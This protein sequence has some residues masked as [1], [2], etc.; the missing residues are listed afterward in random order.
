MFTSVP[1]RAM[2]SKTF[3]LL[4][5]KHF[6][7]LWQEFSFLFRFAKQKLQ[8][9]IENYGIVES[10]AYTE[11]GIQITASAEISYL[12]TIEEYIVSYI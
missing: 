7:R 6:R 9:E 8:N 12:N 11:T 3:L 10:E 5:Q 4:F 1:K 2:E